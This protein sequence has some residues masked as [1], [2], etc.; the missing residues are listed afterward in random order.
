MRAG[1][2]RH[3][4]DV[5]EPELPPAQELLRL[6]DRVQRRERGLQPLARTVLTASQRVVGPRELVEPEDQQPSERAV[7]GVRGPQRRLWIT[8]VEVLV[9][10]GRLGKDEGVLFQNRNPSERV[11]LV[12]PCRAV[13]QINL[14]RL[15]LDS[16]LGEGDPDTRAIRAASSVVEGDHRS[17][18]ASASVGD[19]AQQF[20]RRR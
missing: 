5:R 16:L 20:A 17:I 14:D 12:D 8:V 6:E 13:V 19:L 11:L 10:H 9:D 7:G 4:R 15:V 2:P 18:L 3:V 1:N